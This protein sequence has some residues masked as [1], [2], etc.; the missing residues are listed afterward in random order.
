[1]GIKDMVRILDIS[2]DTLQLKL[3]TLF[4]ADRTP[5]IHVV[6]INEL[7]VLLFEKV[8]SS[9]PFGVENPHI[10][11]LE[12]LSEIGNVFKCSI[13][14]SSMGSRHRRELEISELTYLALKR[15]LDS[16]IISEGYIQD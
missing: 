10:Y 16:N 6:S 12:S 1:M 4:F 14:I 15:V 3:E 7:E 2:V 11:F 5:T 13:R 8:F 9:L